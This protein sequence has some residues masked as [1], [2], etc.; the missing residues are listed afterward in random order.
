MAALGKHHEHLD[1]L[2]NATAALAAI[3]AKDGESLDAM[4]TPELFELMIDLLEKYVVE[5]PAFVYYAIPVI[6]RIY[7]A[8]QRG[9]SCVCV[10]IC[11]CVNV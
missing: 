4:K 1:T 6:Y 11:N 7:G 3:A 8:G 5:E 2:I 9:F 10:S